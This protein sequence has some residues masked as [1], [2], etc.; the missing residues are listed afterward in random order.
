MESIGSQN[1]A[2]Q[3]DKESSPYGAE[4][5]GSEKWL[6]AIII[7]L[8]LGWSYFPFIT[9]VKVFVLEILPDWVKHWETIPSWIPL[10]VVKYLVCFV[11][12]G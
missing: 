3:A 4:V 12:C 11:M 10:H 7:S 9:F 5:G 6:M 8:L 2:M 1:A